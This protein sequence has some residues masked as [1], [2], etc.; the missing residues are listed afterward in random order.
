V[1]QSLAIIATLIVFFA[2]CTHGKKTK[3]VTVSI[4]PTSATVGSGA[5]QQFTA[6]VT[7][8]TS[9]DVTWQV[10]GTTGGSSSEGTIS[11]SGLYTAPG[12]VP[13]PATVTV[14]AVSQADTSASA[15]A[16]VTVGPASSVSISPGSVTVAAA[17][18]Q[19]FEA[20]VKGESTAAVTWEVNGLSGGS[21][22]VG[23]ISSAG[24]Y[25]AP[26]IPPGGQQ[27]TVTAVS[28]ADSSN[29]AA[30]TVT[31]APSAATLNGSYAFVFNGR[32]SGLRLVEAGSFQ[33]DGKGNVTGGTEDV[34]GSAGVFTS[35]AFSGTYTV[36]QDGRGSLVITPSG[37]SG[38]S[39]STFALVLIS[40][41]R[42]LLIANDTTTN[43]S[44]R[45]DLQDSSAFTNSALSGTYVFSL[46]GA[47]GSGFAFSSI[48]FMTLNGL[49]SITTGS[50]D[51]NDNGGVNSGLSIG[52]T[53]KTASNGRGT[54]NLNGNF[55]TYNFAFYVVS[56]Q[57]LRL[58][59]IGSSGGPVWSGTADGQQA[60]IDTS[61]VLDGTFVF[62]AGG[63][64]GGGQ[65]ADAGLFQM[66]SGGSVTNGEAD[67]N[68]RGTV[69]T[70]YAF[71]GSYTLKAN[72]HGTLQFV[73]NGLGTFNYSFYL[74][75]NSQAVLLRTDLEAVTSGTMTVQEQSTFSL[76][77]FNGPF[78]FNLDGDTVATSTVN[79]VPIDKLGQLSATGTGT[80][81]GTEN[82]NSGG[83]LTSDVALAA[84][85]AVDTNGRGTLTV[86]GGGATREVI[87]YLSSPATMFL[88]GIDS[89]Q[90]VL[91]AADQQFQPGGSASPN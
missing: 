1:K 20:T 86:T 53:Y 54:L 37:S 7:N 48:G 6:T 68:N 58:V 36:G 3:S 35:V 79:S 81:T 69:T 76:A 88:I 27:V 71:T 59:S 4:S 31:V 55:G 45:L 80:A 49:G 28:Q 85:N 91:G 22:A 25:T 83:V 65:V 87:F 39:K 19:K 78:G 90:V 51:S 46:D 84:T 82:I 66:V 34:N 32:S 73:N 62:E 21:A 56:A 16:S 18:T 60:D 89:D 77:D 23:T 43:G 29:T 40:G 26:A 61:P 74:V 75:S 9:A 41:E 57:R 11:S 13:N 17:A 72:G 42:A 50:M 70:D 2:S 38:L 14:T 67:E 33:A 30:A 8:A 52:G 10:N 5:E 44:G 64:S 15:S 63:T 47:D 24:L 12:A